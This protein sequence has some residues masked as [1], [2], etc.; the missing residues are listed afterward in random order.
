MMMNHFGTSISVTPVRNHLGA[1]TEDGL[2][3][4]TL[5]LLLLLSIKEVTGPDISLL[6]TLQ[7][8]NRRVR[9]F[10]RTDNLRNFVVH[11][12]LTRNYSAG[13]HNVFLIT[14]IVAYLIEIRL[15]CKFVQ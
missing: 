7:L 10:I 6:T 12:H 5:A 2:R 14:L 1:V 13:V 3:P 9:N 15:R 11:I 4:I 8:G